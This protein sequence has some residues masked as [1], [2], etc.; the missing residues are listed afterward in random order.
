MLPL[1]SECF[2]LWAK[3]ASL[4]SEAS[5]SR[6]LRLLLCE[7]NIHV[8]LSSSSALYFNTCSVSI[9]NFLCELS[10]VEWKCLMETVK[11]IKCHKYRHKYW[12]FDLIG[13]SLHVKKACAINADGHVICRINYE[14]RLH[15][16]ALSQHISAFFADM[17]DV[18]KSCND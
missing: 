14:L 3:A 7:L 10:H 17:A 13:F 1:L 12:T 2:V 16:K 4:H 6:V 18:N 11:W 9:H 8:M 5:T 15:F